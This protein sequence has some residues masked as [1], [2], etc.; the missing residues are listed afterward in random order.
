MYAF[1]AVIAVLFA[2]FDNLV[3]FWKEQATPEFALIGPVI[4]ST[5]GRCV[6][7]TARHLRQARPS[8]II[9]SANLFIKIK[10]SGSGANRYYRPKTV[11]KDHARNDVYWG[12]NACCYRYRYTD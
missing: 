4:T 7:R 11:G 2:F 3:D 6:A 5:L 8:T 1:L 12:Q 10:I 9:R